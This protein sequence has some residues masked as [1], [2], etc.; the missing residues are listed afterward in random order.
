VIEATRGI[1]GAELDETLKFWLSVLTGIAL[2][3]SVAIAV[4]ATSR[5]WQKSPVEKLPPILTRLHDNRT[6][7]K[8]YP[9]R[10]EA[11]GDKRFELQCHQDCRC[12]S[13][14]TPG[15]QALDV[16]AS[17]GM[18]GEMGDLIPGA[19]SRQSTRQR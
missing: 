15:Y 12:A 4:F 11:F 14:G 19:L 13:G 2:S 1:V 9:K 6:T 10:S 16:L 7:A 5:F 18:L 3:L 8:H 17:S